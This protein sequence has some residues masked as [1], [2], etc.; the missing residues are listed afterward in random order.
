MAHTDTHAHHHHAPTCPAELDPGWSLLRLSAAARFG[1]ALVLVLV[2]W[3]ATLA[4]I[5]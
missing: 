3:G 2:L 5:A 4:V 1:L